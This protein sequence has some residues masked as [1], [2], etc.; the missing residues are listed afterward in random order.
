VPTRLNGKKAPLVTNRETDVEI[1]EAKKTQNSGKGG[2][3]VGGDDRIP[4]QHNLLLYRP[5]S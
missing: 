1:G 2:H 3:L 5:Y 4:Q